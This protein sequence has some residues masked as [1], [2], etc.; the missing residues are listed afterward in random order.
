M[1]KQE[2]QA[3]YDALLKEFEAGHRRLKKI[4]QKMIL[5]QAE[6][7]KMKTIVDTRPDEIAMKG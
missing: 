5:L 1:S 3:E 7:G 2:K 4:K 6:I